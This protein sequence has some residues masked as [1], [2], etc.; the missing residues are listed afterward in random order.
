M[1]EPILAPSEL[2]LHAIK[3]RVSRHAVEILDS[4]SGENFEIPETDAYAAAIAQAI[5]VYL[6]ALPIG[7]PR[8]REHSATTK[9]KY[10]APAHRPSDAYRKSLI[11]DLYEAYMTL[12][13]DNPRLRGFKRA[14]DTVLEIFGLPSVTDHDQAILRETRDS[15]AEIASRL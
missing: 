9:Q 8:E 4:V 15:F 6:M 1:A 7:E 5:W 13:G 10:P 12:R 11:G 14:A 3:A 2:S